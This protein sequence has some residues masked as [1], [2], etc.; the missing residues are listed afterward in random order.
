[1]ALRVAC[2]RAQ[3]NDWRYLEFERFAYEIAILDASGAPLAS[4]GSR[5]T[6]LYLWEPAALVR[7]TIPPHA[8]MRSVRIFVAGQNTEYLAGYPY[9]P[10]MHGMTLTVSVPDAPPPAPLSPP[11]APPR[12]P[13]PPLPPPCGPRY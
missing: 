10:E 3:V 7:H 6:T 5:T 2:F 11:P 8:G 13:I 1:M 4:V 9:G 12:V